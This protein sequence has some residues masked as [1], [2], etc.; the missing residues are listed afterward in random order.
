MSTTSSAPVVRVQQGELRGT[1]DRGALAFFGVP[2]AAPPFGPG[3]M[4]APRPASPWN[5]VRDAT[6]YGPTSPKAPYPPQYRP[7][8]P[9]VDIPGE[10][11]LNLNVWTPDTTGSLPVLVWIHGGSFTNGSGSVAEYNGAAFARDGVVTVTINYRLGAEGFLYTG[12]NVANP[13]LL[14]QVA[15]LTWVRGN[16][17]AFGGD[18]ARVTVAGESAGAMSVTTLLSMPA[19]AGLFHQVIAQSGAAAHTLD[20]Q[21]GRMVAGFLAEALGVEPTRE[22][23]AAIPVQQVTAAVSALTEEVQTAPNPAKWG[24]LALSLLPFMPTVDGEVVP[25]PPLEAIAA[26]R[27]ADVALLIGSNQDEA[28]LFFVADGSIGAVDEATLAAAAGA[29]GLAAEGVEVYRRNRPDARP[30]DLLAAIV[31]DWFYRVPAVRVA[32]ARSGSTASTW[33]Y[34]FDYWSPAY[35]GRLGACHGVEIPFVFDTLHVPSTRPRV[36][37]S[38]PQVVADTAHATWVSF[39]R[40]GDPGWEPYTVDARTTGLIN[41]GVAAVDDPAG[42]ERRLWE[43]V[44]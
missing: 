34:R 29:Y 21:D 42:D 31:S 43:G 14:D 8:F 12:D 11:C 20:P 39:I 37:D 17:A 22:A 33:V 2:F 7:L 27:G 30:G 36:G 24:T 23:I 13:G 32:E 25:R 6:E 35:D 28:R 3:R 1:T 16:I 10:D 44:R 5:G 9:E 38:A 26:G 18:P 41:D 19:A 40:R 15:A 4:R